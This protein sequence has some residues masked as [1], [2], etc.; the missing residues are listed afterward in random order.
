[1][2][3]DRVPF[4]KKL[5][6]LAKKRSWA[7]SSSLATV[8]IYER[9]KSFKDCCSKAGP[10][11]SPAS[12]AGPFDSLPG[13]DLV[14]GSDF[15]KGAVSNAGVDFAG[16][17]FA[18]GP[19]SAGELDSVEVVASAMGVAFASGLGSTAGVG[20]AVGPNSAGELDS[21][22]VVASAVGV[23]FASWVS[24][25]GELISAGGLGSTDGVNSANGVGGIEAFDSP[26]AGTDGVSNGAADGLGLI[27]ADGFGSDSNIANSPFSLGA[28][29]AVFTAGAG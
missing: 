2:E 1:M 24:S 14:D 28:G 7:E 23:A 3:I 10:E 15:A 18:V 5:T 26:D 27:S 20:F 8:C 25:P 6:R 4:P 9:T 16:V 13:V 22:E 11:P 21:V 17:G 19:N 29:L 12:A